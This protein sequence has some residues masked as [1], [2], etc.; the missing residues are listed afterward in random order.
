MS[1]AFDWDNSETR[2]E[3]LINNIINHICDDGWNREKIL[4][5]MANNSEFELTEEK[6]NE[7]T[8]VALERLKALYSS[9]DYIEQTYRQ[10]IA[11]YEHIYAYF[12][13]IGHAQGA[14]KALQAKEKLMKILNEG[15][16]VTLKKSETII[17]QSSEPDYDFSKLT[18]E[19]QEELRQLMNKARA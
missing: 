2:R 17:H 8:D 15:N 9:P 1:N 4:Q 7:L 5:V 12:K 13:K 14:N 11:M 6:V 10:H 3:I 19:E 16:K 18:P